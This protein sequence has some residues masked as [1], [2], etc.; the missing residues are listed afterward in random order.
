MV[1]KPYTSTFKHFHF[2][3]KH[4]G[5]YTNHSHK[6]SYLYF[7][8]WL[9]KPKMST[10]NMLAPQFYLTYLSNFLR[11]SNFFEWTYSQPI[12]WFLHTQYLQMC[13]QHFC[14]CEL[15]ICNFTLQ[16]G[17]TTPWPLIIIDNDCACN[18]WDLHWSLSLLDA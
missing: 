4:V 14:L 2:N 6:N 12:D 15:Q 7:R 1:I 3:S 11:P 13:L 10:Y 5:I 8:L 16:L 18:H 9:R 17:F